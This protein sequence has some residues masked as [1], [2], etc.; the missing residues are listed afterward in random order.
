MMKHL[1]ATLLLAALVP[2]TTQAQERLPEYLQAEKFTLEKLNTMLFS[3]KVE[4]HWLPSGNGFWYEYKTSEGTNWY[5]VNTTNRQQRPLFDR[6]ELAAQLTQI[7]HD[8]FDAQHLPMKQLKV[9]EDGHT[10]F[11]EVQSTADKKK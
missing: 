4:P 6:D 7:V 10:F 1:I 8:P 5:L 2:L 11:F 9:G 3:T